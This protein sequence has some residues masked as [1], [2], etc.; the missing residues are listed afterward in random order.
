MC[1]FFSIPSRNLN[2]IGSFGENL[3]EVDF[4][5]FLD[6]CNCAVRVI[7]FDVLKVT[8]TGNPLFYCLVHS[9]GKRRGHV[10]GNILSKAD[11]LHLLLHLGDSTWLKTIVTDLIRSRLVYRVRISDI[12]EDIAPLEFRQIILSPNVISLF[13]TPYPQGP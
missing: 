10:H 6:H 12:V 4:A 11:S 3:R 9:D 2:S 1:A 8:W 7:A 13:I 5:V